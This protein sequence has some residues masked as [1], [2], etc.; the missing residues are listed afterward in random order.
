MLENSTKF[1]T[2]RSWD[3]ILQLQAIPCARVNNN[4]VADPAGPVA[5]VRSVFDVDFF[6]KGLG[7]GH[8][9]AGAYAQ[10]GLRRL[11]SI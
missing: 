10:S 11:P 7:N 9:P 4:A 1:A 5:T 6:R 2:M 3:I 8:S